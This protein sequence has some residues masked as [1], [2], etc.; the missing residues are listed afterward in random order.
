MGTLDMRLAEQVAATTV[1]E[2]KSRGLKQTLARVA[3]CAGSPQPE[4]Q[5]LEVDSN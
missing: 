1:L 5:P 2:A 4:S 3:D